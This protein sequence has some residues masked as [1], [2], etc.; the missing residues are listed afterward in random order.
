MHTGVW[1][2]ILLR[3]RIKFALKITICPTVKIDNIF[4]ENNFLVSSKWGWK[5]YEN[6]FYP[7]EFVHNGFLCNVNWPITLHLVWSR[8]HLLYAFQFAYNVNSA[9]TLFMQSSRGA[10]IGKFCSYL[11]C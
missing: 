4:S 6:L 8:W 10:V 3:G 11:A 2:G 7:V 1:E 9:I 5:H